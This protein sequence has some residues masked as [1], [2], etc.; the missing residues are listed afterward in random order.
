MVIPPAKSI[1]WSYD[2]PETIE[3]FPLKHHLPAIIVAAGEVLFRSK[4][5]RNIA[6]LSV[7]NA[8]GASV[9]PM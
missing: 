5:A 7:D 1:I 9:M 8:L 3:S 2:F 4:V 6:V